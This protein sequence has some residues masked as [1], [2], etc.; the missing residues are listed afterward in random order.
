MEYL[1]ETRSVEGLVQLLAC[2]LLPHGYWFYV[3][4][5]IPE[6]KDPR[7]VDAKLIEK[8]GVDLGRTARARR[9]RLGQANLR[10]LRHGRFFVLIAT[11]GEHFSLRTRPRGFGTS[12]TCPCGSPGIRSATAAEIGLATGCPMRW[13][14]H[15]EINR[16]RYKELQAWFL[17]VAVH[18]SAARVAAECYHVPF[19]P[20]PRSGGRCSSCCAWSMPF[21]SGLGTRHFLMPC[22]RCAGESSGRLIRH[23]DGRDRWRMNKEVST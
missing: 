23:E 22:C 2:N 9:K 12:V 15:V 20:M 17:E 19:D 4:G 10:Y 8:Y 16:Q 14:A 1:C 6:G 5:W 11:H 7:R 18:R 3:S 13:H 21:A